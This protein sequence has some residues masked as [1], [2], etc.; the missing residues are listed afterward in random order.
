MS[1]NCTWPKKY[2]GLPTC[3]LVIK[4]YQYGPCSLVHSQAYLAPIYIERADL[5]M[6]G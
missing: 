1:L 3:Q 2:V 4:T 5:L 6:S